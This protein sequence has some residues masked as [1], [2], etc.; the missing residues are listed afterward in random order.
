LL[1]E[2]AKGDSQRMV[3]CDLEGGINTLFRVREGFL[4][5]VLVVCEPTVKSIET[6]DRVLAMCDRLAFEAVILGNRLRD[7]ADELLIT[8][9]FPG[10]RFVAIPDDDGIAEADRLGAA[11]IDHAPDGPGVVAIAAL[12][13]SLLGR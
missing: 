11:P 5:A 1:G 4:D 7:A 10:R 13:H 9:R 2:L 6:T 8:E 3:I 12:A